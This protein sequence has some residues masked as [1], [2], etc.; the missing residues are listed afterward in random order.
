M[1]SIK[2]TIA[3]LQYVHAEAAGALAN[4]ALIKLL[5]KCPAASTS[6]QGAWLKACASVFGTTGSGASLIEVV[7]TPATSVDGTARTP[8]NKS[9]LDTPPTSPVTVF[10]NTDAT[11]GTQLDRGDAM[12]SQNW[13]SCYW[14]LKPATNYLVRLTNQSGGTLTNG[15]LKVELGM[16]QGQV[17][18][19]LRLY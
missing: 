10:L 3:K 13:E 6:F 7:E 5:L 12:V 14:L 8:Q 19:Y 2:Q 4:A 18:D 9:R 15:T 1:S 11:G 16:I 17:V